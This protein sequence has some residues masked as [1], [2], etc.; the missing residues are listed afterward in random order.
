MLKFSRNTKTTAENLFIGGWIIPLFFYL[1]PIKTMGFDS[2][3]FK[4]Y[5]REAN[6]FNIGPPTEIE[7]QTAIE[8]KEVEKIFGWSYSVALSIIGSENPSDLKKWEYLRDLSLAQTPNS[9][10]SPWESYA[11][12]EIYLI[13]G[14]AKMR[15]GQRILGA[16]DLRISWNISNKLKQNWPSFTPASK[17]FYLL[18]TLT[19]LV[20][21]AYRS[22][23]DF[24]GFQGSVQEG[25]IEMGKI[26]RST[27]SGEYQFINE[28]HGF[29]WLIVLK[30]FGTEQDLASAIKVF[31]T[32]KKTGS[33]LTRYAISSAL[34]S[35]GR[36]QEAAEILFSKQNPTKVPFPWIIWLK[37]NYLL[38]EINPE[39]EKYF[40]E[41]ISLSRGAS[42]SKASYM[43][44][45]WLNQCLGKDDKYLYFSNKVLS[46]SKAGIDEDIEAQREVENQTRHETCL[47]R[48]RL[49][50]DGG[51]YVGALSEINNCSPSAFNS[52]RSIEEFHYRLG[53]IY[54]KIGDESA[55]MRMFVKCLSVPG[56]SD[57]YFKPNSALMM[58]GIME[59]K[60]R[61]S[62]AVKFYET[63][64]GF[65]NHEYERSIENKAREGLRRI[66]QLD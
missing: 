25:L 11:K 64:I 57:A 35:L 28:Q 22:I 61:N 48:S 52:L 15:A 49:R 14:L 59:K 21:A 53:R 2:T 4:K 23:A 38:H 1:L 34:I 8:R 39:A 37:A 62:E 54:L 16:N 44:L 55:A 12:S 5:F 10:T 65:R 6:N 66:E 27:T 56:I 7:L 41:F 29:I 13:W 60:G 3:A 24:L 30:N 33:I 63:A 43:R 26:F 36:R 17:N 31:S 9:E 45:A 46:E 50:F 58:A 47:L 19:G 40:L 42:Y 32:Y 20:P 18:R 51:D